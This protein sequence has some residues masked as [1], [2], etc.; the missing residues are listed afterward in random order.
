MI[1]IEEVEQQDYQDYVA[2]IKK[3]F[4]E[5]NNEMQVEEY[6]LFEGKNAAGELVLVQYFIG[7]NSLTIIG[8][9]DSE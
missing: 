4:T 3:D 8:N 2:K 7:D 6:L 5:E 1:I 9:R